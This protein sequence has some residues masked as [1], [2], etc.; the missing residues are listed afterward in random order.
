VA[1]TRRAFLGRGIGLY[2]ASLPQRRPDYAF[3]QL[4][5]QSADSSLHRRLV[6]MWAAVARE[7]NGR[8]ETA[9]FPENR[10]V[11]G[12]DPAVLSM[13]RAGEIQFFTL[14]GGIL[15]GAVPAAA[16]QQVPFAFRSAAHAHAVMDGALGAYL[17]GELTA[18]GIHGF[19]V[20]A[21][22]NGMRQIA[23]AVR[24]IRTPADLAGLRVRVPAGEIFTDTFRAFGAD[25]VVLNVDEIHDGLRRGRVDAQENPLAVVELFRLYEVVRYVSLS[26]HMWS[27]FNQLAHLGTWRRLPG[28]I[29][30]VIERNVAAFVRLQRRDQQALNASLVTGLARRGL[31]F[32][33]VDQTPFRAALRG[34]YAGWRARLGA[35]AWSLV[36]A[37]IR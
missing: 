29:R 27:G 6:E 7:T 19:P 1:L 17:R 12:S 9:V 35:K 28:D 5:N 16:V 10:G 15:A 36:A 33:D 22:D 21:F 8:V 14:M 18:K 37:E 20:G 30:A 32:N 26:N 11:P 4:H 23:C 24:P 2:A 34:M 3:V 13:L 25:P 31:A